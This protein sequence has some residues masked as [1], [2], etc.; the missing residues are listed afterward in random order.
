MVNAT[1]YWNTRLKVIFD[2]REKDI[3][4]IEWNP[5]GSWVIEIAKTPNSNLFLDYNVKSNTLL[6]MRVHQRQLKGKFIYKT[7]FFERYYL[8]NAKDEYK[9]NPNKILDIWI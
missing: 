3:Y 2:K 7:N 6:Q 8:E 5:R 4:P 1:E 9:N